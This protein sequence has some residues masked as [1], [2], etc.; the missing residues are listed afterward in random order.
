MLTVYHILG[1]VEE[2]GLSANNIPPFSTYHGTYTTRFVANLLLKQSHTDKRKRNILIWLN[3][4]RDATSKGSAFGALG[5]HIT[6][7][8]LGPFPE[9]PPRDPVRDMSANGGSGDT[10]DVLSSSEAFP[11]DMMR[12]DGCWPSETLTMGDFELRPY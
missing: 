1:I 8:L 3:P 11:R 7:T 2:V 6:G 10:F 9:L 5:I 4:V 12:S